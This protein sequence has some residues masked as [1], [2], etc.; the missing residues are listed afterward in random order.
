MGAAGGVGGCVWHEACLCRGKC[1]RKEIEVAVR[2][3]GDGREGDASKVCATK[4]L[5]G[6][7]P[8]LLSTWR[9]STPSPP[10]ASPC[11]C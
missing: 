2:Q 1:G 9:Y 7:G 5:T 4:R 11:Y 8:F 6:G 3:G 10:W